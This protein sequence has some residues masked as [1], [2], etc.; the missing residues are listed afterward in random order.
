MEDRKLYHLVNG[1][2]VHDGMPYNTTNLTYAE[3]AE[4]NA[5]WDAVDIIPEI[6]V[7]ESVT[8]DGIGNGKRSDTV[9]SSVF[10]AMM[11]EIL[12]EHI[13]E[14]CRVRNRRKADRKHKVLPKERK[15]REEMRKDR[16]FGYCY[17]ENCPKVMFAPDSL[18]IN[19][20]K[21]AESDRIARADFDAEIHQHEDAMQ[22]YADYCLMAEQHEE[23]L[24]YL[25]NLTGNVEFWEIMI[26]EISREKI[27]EENRI[28]EMRNIANNIM[29]GECY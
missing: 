6:P 18:P 29:K 17:N 23:R 28:R 2:F 20:R 14:K 9:Q 13:A 25:R 10:D 24:E 4:C 22:E 8:F 11:A 19:Y 27:Y 7:A 21:D 15:H 1:E 16:M 26:D 12:G 5:L 3:I